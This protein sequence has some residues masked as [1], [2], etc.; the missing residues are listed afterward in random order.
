[1]AAL[2]LFFDGHCPFCASEMAR[3]Q[4]WDRYGA[5][6]FVDIASPHF[7]PASLGVTAADL[8]REIHSQ[9]GN[10]KLLIGIDSL[11]AA[12]TLVGKRWLVWPLALRP[13][14]PAFAALYRSFAR[15]RY[16]I[17]A[18]LGYRQAPSCADGVCGI[19]NPL[20]RG[21]K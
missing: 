11:L 21:H 6:A 13:L 12:Y 10:G 17:S 4:Q 14:R 18:W 16:R 1:M 19:G 2:T 20:F 8:D 9:D 7:E 3:L 5:L 15:N